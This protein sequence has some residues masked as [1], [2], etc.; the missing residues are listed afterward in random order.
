MSLVL[1]SWASLACSSASSTLIPCP[2]QGQTAPKTGSM[3]CLW[4]WAALAWPPWAEPLLP[5]PSSRATPRTCLAAW[6]TSTTS[7]P[8]RSTHAMWWS[9]P[10]TTVWVMSRASAAAPGPTATS[11]RYW[12][13]WGR[14]QM[15]TRHQPLSTLNYADGQSGALGL[16]AIPETS[17]PR[18]LSHSM[19]QTPVSKANLPV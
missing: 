12:A 17:F 2:G 14:M 7:V 6:G 15:G 8:V 9:R 1:G 5:A 4:R 18:N 19:C 16:T 13:G 10:S 3:C 11:L